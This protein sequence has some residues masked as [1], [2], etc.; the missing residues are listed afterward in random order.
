MGLCKLEK[1]DYISVKMSGEI[2][3]K[4]RN[5]GRNERLHKL[6]KPDYIR[7]KMSGEI[8]EKWRHDREERLI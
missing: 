1:P 3:E 8:K 7:V 4:R 5:N 2:K 6:E